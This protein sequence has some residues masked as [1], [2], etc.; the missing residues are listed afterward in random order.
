MTWDLKWYDISNPCLSMLQNEL[1]MIHLFHDSHERTH[2]GFR[3][4]PFGRQMNTLTRENGSPR[5]TFHDC[6]HTAPAT[7]CLSHN[8]SRSGCATLNLMPYLDRRRKEFPDNQ[9]QSGHRACICWDLDPGGS[10]GSW[11]HTMP[12]SNVH[13][14]S[15]QHDDLA[16]LGPGF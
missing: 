5:L 9:A 12:R 1:E 13:D 10:F 11:C 2:S 4:P 8:F 14:S 3:N 7:P 15:Q 16:R 6:N